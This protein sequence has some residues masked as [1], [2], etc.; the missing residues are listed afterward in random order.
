MFINNFV[1]PDEYSRSLDDWFFVAQR[2]LFVH[3]YVDK[4]RE[5]IHSILEEIPDYLQVYKFALGLKDFRRSLVH[6][7]RYKTTSQAIEIALVYEDR[8][9]FGSQ[10]PNVGKTVEGNNK[11]FVQPDKG[12]KPQEV[13]VT[14]QP[15]FFKRKLLE[16]SNFSS[17]IPKSGL[18]LE[19]QNKAKQEGLCFG[20][21]GQHQIKDCSKRKLKVLDNAIVAPLVVRNPKLVQTL[22]SR[23]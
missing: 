22:T 12:K 18:T 11:V 4:Y 7:E 6:R 2:N 9:K 14:N 20:C 10:V 16:S 3:E 21:L 17:K 13:V 19:Q 15:S 1:P 5:I 23:P 8:R